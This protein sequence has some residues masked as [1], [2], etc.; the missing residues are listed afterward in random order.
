MTI[1]I[2][3]FFN[4][5]T[6]LPVVDVRSEGEFEGGH[7]KHAINIPLLTNAE[8]VVVGTDY[9]QK[10]QAEAIKSGLR[11]VG[12]R[13]LEM[14]IEA[15]K[16]AVK[17]EMIVHCWR[18]GMRS[19]N[20]CQFVSMNGI[21]THQLIGGYKS[22]RQAALETFSKPLQ[23]VVIGGYTGSG[24]SEIL[25]ALSRQGEQVIDLEKLASHCGSAFGGLMQPPQPTTEQFQN[26][27]FEELRKMDLNQRIWIEDESIAIGKVFLPSD[28]WQT[29]NVSPVVEIT[30]DKPY[31]IN[32][33]V[34]E[35][36]K[37][38]KEEF[39]KSMERITK[40]LGGQHFKAAKEKLLEGD[41]AST[42]EILLNYYDKAYLNGLEKKKNR[43]KATLPWNGKNAAAFSE[44]LL[45]TVISKEQSD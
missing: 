40:K 5:R 36:G 34:K 10:G 37:A 20:F 2:D 38:D 17:H 43:I 44:T 1:T 16:V 22:Y 9:K 24:K 41:M 30:L 25:W 33:L 23:F 3:D 27:L 26:N 8:R 35:Y 18:G 7:I 45:D 15:E 12:P 6:T 39:L 13:L 28:L 29:M 42:I 19:T 31:R 11:L 4:L 21:K 32:R 14:I